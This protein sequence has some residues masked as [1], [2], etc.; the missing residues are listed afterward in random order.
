[1]NFIKKS[2]PLLIIYPE[3]PD[4]SVLESVNLLLTPHF[5]TLKKEAIPVRFAY[6]A[7]K[8][9]PSLFDGYVDNLHECKYHV[10]KDGE[11][12]LFIAYNPSQIVQFLTTHKIPIAKVNKLFFAQE[13][14]SHFAI[15][16]PLQN[17]EVLMDVDGIITIFPKFLLGSSELLGKIDETFTPQSGGFSL[18]GVSGLGTQITQLQAITI[19][20][21]LFGFGM[22]FF[23]EGWQSDKEDSTSSQITQLIQKDSSLQSSYTR[24]SVIKKYTAIDTE[25]RIKR[26]SIKKV[27]QVLFEGVKL[28]KL[29]LEASK[30]SVVFICSTPQALSRLT[31]SIRGH[32]WNL[33]STN[34]KTNTLEAEIS[35]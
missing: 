25:E 20:S 9:A 24:E 29:D 15:P 6:Q 19:S 1:M 34:P 28:Q 23:V 31:S 30:I 26:D 21:I 12:W 33:K 7:K 14:S 35:L 16:V 18:V 5:Y 2:K 8:I 4:V 22:L 27:S 13:L 17:D 11:E 32:Q 10:Y 3:M